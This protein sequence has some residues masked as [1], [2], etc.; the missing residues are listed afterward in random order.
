MIRYRSKN[1]YQ[2][3]YLKEIELLAQILVSIMG[4]VINISGRG[5]CSMSFKIF[6]LINN[7][8]FM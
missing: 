4:S 6:T 5:R 2:E 7:K 1:K 8:I 3:A